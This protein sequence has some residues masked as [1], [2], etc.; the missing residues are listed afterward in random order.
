MPHYGV[1]TNIVISST[2]PET[3]FLC[4]LLQETTIPRAWIERM[5]HQRRVSFLQR[6]LSGNALIKRWKNS[7][8]HIWILLNFQIHFEDGFLWSCLCSVFCNKT[9]W[10][11][12]W[13]QVYFNRVRIKD[14]IISFDSDLL[15]NL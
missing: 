9:R 3:R 10:F 15:I 1:Q 8:E 7:D 4:V 2:R 6:E 13:C 11:Y 12:S 14:L 5:L